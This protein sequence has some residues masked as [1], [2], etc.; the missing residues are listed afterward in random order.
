MLVASNYVEITSTFRK[1]PVFCQTVS[2]REKQSFGKLH[3]PTS[4]HLGFTLHLGKA[5]GGK[6]KE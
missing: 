2:P 6:Q 5:S 4:T 1:A 3:L